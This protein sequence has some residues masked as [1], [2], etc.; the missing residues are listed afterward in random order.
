MEKQNETKKIIGRTLEDILKQEETFQEQLDFIKKDIFPGKI[1][2]SPKKLKPNPFQN[3]KKYRPEQTD[4]LGEFFK[5]N[6]FL[7]PLFVRKRNGEYEII[8]GEK[9]WQAA[10]L[11]NIEEIPVIVENID[12]ATMK[13]ITVIEKLQS[14]DATPL[15]EAILY[16]SLIDE[17]HYSHNDIAKRIGKSRPYVS[18][19]VRILSLP[20]EVLSLLREDKIT[21]SHLRPFI[22]QDDKTV[23]QIAKKIVKE[24]L[25]VRQC[26]NI[27]KKEQQPLNVKI[28]NK[29]IIIDFQTVKERDKILKKLR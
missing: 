16:K 15:E 21:V 9:R 23:I 4:E 14:D 29:Q 25:S 24:N 26:E 13:E 3:E 6:G 5:R 12:D 11:A 28:Q 27:L 8:S 19:L 20:T 10:L 22:G 18:N 17:Y 7:M 2:I 1:L